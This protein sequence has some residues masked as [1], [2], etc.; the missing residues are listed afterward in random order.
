[1]R[2]AVEH[3]VSIGCRRI[4]H[5][6]TMVALERVRAARAKTYEESVQ[7]AGIA[8]ELI[9]APDETRRGAFQ[10]IAEYVDAHGAPDGIF[11]LNDD[12]AIGAYRALRDRGMRVPEDVAL[13]GCD[14]VEDGE[15]LD[16]PLTTIVQPV[17]EMC[18]IAWDVLSRRIQTPDAALSQT[19]L[20]PELRLAASTR[21]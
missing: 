18:R 15:F 2:Q 17:H 10:I 21:R 1:M 9:L 16:V 20:K 6:S 3:L 8:P 4:A 13:V 12:M 5:L 14:G 7:A 19:L 11:C